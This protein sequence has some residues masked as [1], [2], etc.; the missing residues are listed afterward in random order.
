MEAKSQLGVIRAEIEGH[1]GDKVN[2]KD[3]AGRKKIYI[4][5]GVIEKAYSSIFT[6]KVEGDFDRRVAYSYSDI[7][8]K[9]VQIQYIA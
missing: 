6:V 8:T 1:V 3:S 2:L 5:D 4:K 9:T 7:L